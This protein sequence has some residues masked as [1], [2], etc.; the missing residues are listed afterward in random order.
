V[1]NT[2]KSRHLRSLDPIQHEGVF[3]EQVPQNHFI[4]CRRNISPT[5]KRQKYSSTLH[6]KKNCVVSMYFK[7][8]NEMNIDIS[9]EETITFQKTPPSLCN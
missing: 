2:A 4:L 9:I 8:C 6:K 7:L 3:L 5:H 1:Y